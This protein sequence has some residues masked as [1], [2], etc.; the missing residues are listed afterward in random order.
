MQ[1]K[2]GLATFK[3][4][5]E[6]DELRKVFDQVVHN[7]NVKDNCKMISRIINPIELEQVGEFEQHGNYFT[8]RFKIK[9]L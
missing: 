2:T 4:R 5:T 9:K 7:I 1:V 6:R 8:L 3:L